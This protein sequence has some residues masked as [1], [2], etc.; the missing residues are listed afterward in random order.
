M[1]TL[2]S[3]LVSDYPRRPNHNFFLDSGR[4]RA[5]GLGSGCML[6]IPVLADDQE[7]RL[8][9]LRPI[10]HLGPLLGEDGPVLSFT[11]GLDPSAIGGRATNVTREA[12]RLT[13]VLQ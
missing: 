8:R 1:V 3:Y 9:V 6:T 4:C 2:I 11:I 13:A 7:P 10:L 5:L 12:E